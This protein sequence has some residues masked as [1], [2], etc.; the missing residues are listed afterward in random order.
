MN[1]TIQDTI[2]FL[3]TLTIDT[4][5]KVWNEKR[6]KEVLE[7]LKNMDKCNGFCGVYECNENQKLGICKRL[8]RECE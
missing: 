4:G 5:I 6:R 1:K 8:N 3:E 2:A 7:A